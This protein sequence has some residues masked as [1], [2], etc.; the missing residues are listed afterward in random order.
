MLSR[1][2]VNLH[3]IDEQTR[4]QFLDGRAARENGPPGAAHFLEKLERVRGELSP[5]PGL[6]RGRHREEGRPKGPMDKRVLSGEKLREENIR[7]IRQLVQHPEYQIAFGMRPPCGSEC[8]ARD[9]SHH[10]R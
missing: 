5:L 4:R 3:G 8:L 9:Q 1:L 7:M 10:I 6:A 2:R